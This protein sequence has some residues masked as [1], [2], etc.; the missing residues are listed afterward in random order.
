[1]VIGVGVL[2]VWLIIM[3]QPLFGIFSGFQVLFWQGPE[4]WAQSGKSSVLTLSIVSIGSALF[5]FWKAN[6]SKE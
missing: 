1:M 5:C 4:E 2:V 3:S 6:R